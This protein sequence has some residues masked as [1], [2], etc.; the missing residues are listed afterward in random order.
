MANGNPLRVNTQGK[1]FH[2]LPRANL[3]KPPILTPPRRASQW[4]QLVPIACA[5]NGTMSHGRAEKSGGS[6]LLVFH[7]VSCDCASELTTDLGVGG[8]NP[9]GRAMFFN[10]LRAAGLPHGSAGWFL[11]KSPKA[12]LSESRRKSLNLV[13]GLLSECPA[14]S[15]NRKN[16]A[17]STACESWRWSMQ[18]SKAAKS[19][20][21]SSPASRR[22]SSTSWIEAEH[23]EG[24]R[25]KSCQ[26]S[27]GAEDSVKGLTA[28]ANKGLGMDPTMP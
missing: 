23:E 25:E 20:P 21:R 15:L 8:S 28:P 16:T 11:A 19:S 26:R 24:S 4:A 5:H 1:S 9:S 6:S 22:R 3:G 27:Q 18:K 13:K 2:L 7:F 12:I 10:T 17:T 14:T